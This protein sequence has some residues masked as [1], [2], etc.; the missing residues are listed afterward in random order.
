MFVGLFNP[1]QSVCVAGGCTDVLTSLDGISSVPEAWL[2]VGGTAL[3]VAAG[4]GVCV[5]STY[6]A[7]SSTLQAAACTEQ[8]RQICQFDC[9]LGNNNNN[10]YT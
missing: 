9:P 10:L 3:N 5:R 2:D 1:G 7:P 8:H 6:G 4:S